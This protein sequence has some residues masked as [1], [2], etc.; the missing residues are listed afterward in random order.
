MPGTWQV[1]RAL[2]VQ[3]KTLC[4]RSGKDQ[5]RRQELQGGQ[6]VKSIPGQGKEHEPGEQQNV[7]EFQKMMRGGGEC[8]VPYCP[9]LHI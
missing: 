5:R 1:Q 6:G 2:E 7:A 4:E 8:V 9:L 3:G